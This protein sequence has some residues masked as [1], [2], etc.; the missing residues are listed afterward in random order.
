MAQ[1]NNFYNPKGYAL[2]I[3]INDYTKSGGYSDLKECVNDVIFWKD[4]FENTWEY[5]HVHTMINQEATAAK[6]YTGIWCMAAVAQPGDIVA[7]CFSGH[8]AQS[9][10]NKPNQ[11]STCNYL[12][13]ADG[14]FVTDFGIN[15]LFKA[16]KPKVRIVLVTDA[17]QSGSFVEEY[18]DLYADPSDDG[19]AKMVQSI[20]K[21]FPYDESKLNQLLKNQKSIKTSAAVAH[22]GAINDSQFVPDGITTDF[23]KELSWGLEWYDILQW[24]NEMEYQYDCMFYKDKLGLYSFLDY[25][26]GHSQPLKNF[27]TTQKNIYGKSGVT[28]YKFLMYLYQQGSVKIEKFLNDLR[29]VSII[30]ADKDIQRRWYKLMRVIIEIK[31]RADAFNPT[32]NFSGYKSIAFRTQYIFTKFSRAF[33]NENG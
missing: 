23:I 15:L 14:E 11:H 22:Y 8:G 32:L 17:C 26:E 16:F 28:N 30:I 1:T 12:L 27:M 7:I 31:Q 5:D 33:Y 18:Y 3:G 9:N 10:E 6:I 24:R 20:I 29:A 19:I 13:G 2:L 21:T 25:L 4:K